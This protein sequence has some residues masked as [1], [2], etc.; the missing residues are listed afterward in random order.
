[1]C[2][3]HHKN[4]NYRWKKN[5]YTNSLN[6][7]YRNEHSIARDER[8]G[9]RSN[10]K[11]I[12]RYQSDQFHHRLAW[13]MMR[14]GPECGGF[15][16]CG[17]QNEQET[18][19]RWWSME[20]QW[21]PS[22]SCRWPLAVDL[23]AGPPVT[24]VTHAHLRNGKTLDLT[25]HRPALSIERRNWNNGEN[26]ANEFHRV[27]MSPRPVDWI[28]TGQLALDQLWDTKGKTLRRSTSSVSDSKLGLILYSVWFFVNNVKYDTARDKIKLSMQIVSD[29][30]GINH[31]N[32][33]R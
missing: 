31:E 3:L 19:S 32:C 5:N 21:K 20:K 7:K 11:I 8:D 24:Y 23:V 28:L 1:M 27:S 9:Q 4:L 15:A 30:A 16:G 22:D 26:S 25:R 14:I 29:C 2:Y 18:K 17:R 33:P 10:V 13:P 6:N 12:E